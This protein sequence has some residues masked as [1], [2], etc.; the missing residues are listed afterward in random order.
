[1]VRY[2]QRSLKY[3]IGL[4]VIYSVVVGAASFVTSAVITPGMQFRAIISTERGMFLLISFFVISAVYPLFGYMR[5]Y[6]KGDMI[7]NREQILASF[8]KQGMKLDHESE[9]RMTFIS[10]SFLRRVIMLFEDHVKVVQEGDG[11]ISVAGNRKAVA[12]VLYRLKYAIDKAS[13][14]ASNEATE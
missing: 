7:L 11:R 6:T 2:L 1:M 9:G 5:R 3:F 12:Y 13:E 8:N 14:R 10:R 4:C